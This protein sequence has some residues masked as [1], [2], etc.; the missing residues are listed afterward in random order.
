[1]AE[2][3]VTELVSNQELQLLS[4][5]LQQYGVDRARVEHDIVA[6]GQSGGEGVEGGVLDDIH[7]G[8]GASKALAAMFDGSVQL[9]EL[10]SGHLDAICL[11]I[12][13]HDVASKN[14]ESGNEN[15]PPA[16]RREKQG[17]EDEDADGTA[18]NESS[19]F[20]AIAK[21]FKRSGLGD[22]KDRGRLGH[23]TMR[24]A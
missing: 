21:V 2:L 18:K 23:S 20:T 19:S 22:G 8:L 11:N 15:N 4:V 6:E 3:N 12:C 9:R 24:F 17:D 16:K 14:P 7:V 1:M 10:L 5:A 13:G